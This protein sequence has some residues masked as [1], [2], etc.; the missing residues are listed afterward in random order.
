M[1]HQLGI[2]STNEDAN[3]L[4][5]SSLQCALPLV[6]PHLCARPQPVSPLRYLVARFHLGD[7][8]MRLTGP[9]RRQLLRNTKVPPLSRG[10]KP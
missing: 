5:T 3:E 4:S 9:N 1:V 7:L 8:T 10:A 2:F 6:A